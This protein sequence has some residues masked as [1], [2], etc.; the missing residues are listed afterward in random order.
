MT[1]TSN[2]IL[3]SQLLYKHSTTQR[4]NLGNFNSAYGNKTNNLASLHASNHYWSIN[5]S[6]KRILFYIPSHYYLHIPSHIYMTTIHLW[7][8]SWH[9]GHLEVPQHFLY[10]IQD[11][12]FI[13][14]FTSFIMNFSV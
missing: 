2:K 4:Y 3:L 14:H 6:I 10:K 11:Q 8:S 9:I 7:M 1:T 13:N 5:L 12:H